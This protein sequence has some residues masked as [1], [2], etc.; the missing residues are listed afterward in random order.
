VEVQYKEADQSWPCDRHRQ[1][2]D[3]LQFRASGGVIIILPEL[4]TTGDEY[5]AEQ[6]RVID[7]R[8]QKSEDE[9]K[10]GRRLFSRAGQRKAWGGWWD[11]NPRHPEPQSGAT[12]N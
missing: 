4:P 11:L 10:N 8:L 3:R 12:T 1:T 5:T 7:A 2:G 9:F 6:R